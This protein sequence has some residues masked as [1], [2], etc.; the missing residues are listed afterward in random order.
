M[1]NFLLENERISLR[2]EYALR[3]CNCILICLI[4]LVVVVGVSLFAAYTT[5]YLEKNIVNAEL[6]ATKNSDVAK[7]KTDF[8]QEYQ[9]VMEKYRAFNQQLLVPTDFLKIILEK[10]P[11][12]VEIVSYN[13]SRIE[14][15]KLRVRI[16]IKGVSKTR[17]SLVEYVDLLKQQPVIRSAEVPIST[18]T[19]ETD[20]SFTIG[21][22]TTDNLPKI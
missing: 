9:Q 17:N 2:R 6:E 22:E 5:V 8:E 13:F 10:K 19:K 21:I 12:E 18:F 20:V 1:L 15:D 4:I 7:R 14:E 3:L 16:D 11:A